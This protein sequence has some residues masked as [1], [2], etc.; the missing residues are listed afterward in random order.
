MKASIQATRHS[1]FQNHAPLSEEPQALTLEQQLP[2]LRQRLM[3][4][5]RVAVSEAALAEDLVQETLLVVF[6]QESTHRGQASLA[7]WAT[8]ILKNKVADWYRSPQRK[9]FVEPAKE[10]A[11]DELGEALEALYQADGHYVEKVPHWQQP[12]NS[13]EQR[14]MRAVLQHCVDCLPRQTARVF[15]MREWLGFE[16]AEICTRL[17]INAENCRTILHRA[18]MGLRE[19]MQLNWLSPQVNSQGAV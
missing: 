10:Q 12:D 17:C 16:T 2:Q 6:Q 7:T 18:R 3:R 1:F 14:Q 5:A 11:D 9:Y 8:A 19:C 4:Q 13:L 15:M